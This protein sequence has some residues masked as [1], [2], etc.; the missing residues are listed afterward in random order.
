MHMIPDI[1]GHTRTYPYICNSTHLF[2]MLPTICTNLE[3]Y[4]HIYETH[5]FV[6]L[7]I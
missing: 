6:M 1:P 7:P 2:A 4:V 3:L 5:L